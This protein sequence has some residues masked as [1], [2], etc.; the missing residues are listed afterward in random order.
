MIKPKDN[1]IFAVAKDTYDQIDK[2]GLC[3]ENEISIQRLK[4]SLRPF[5][6][7]ILDIDDKN[8]YSDF[9]KLK[10]IKNLR[11]DVAILKLGKEN[12]VVLINNVDYYQSLEH[13]FTG[14]T[15]FKQI[16]KD[17]TMTQLSTLQNYLKSLFKR[18]ELTEEQYKN[19]RPQNARAGRAHVLPKIH[20]PFT[21][22]PKFRLSVDTTSTCYYNVGSYLTELLNP[23][24]QNEFI[25]GDSFDATNKIKSVPPEFFDDG[26]IFAYFD[27]KSLFTNVPLQQTISIILDRVYDNKFVASTKRP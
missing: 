20:K 8:V 12:G 18:G 13:L 23:P 7:N 9:M 1:E 3:K 10:V 22:L 16:E 25:I 5:T 26:Y 21:V 27:V 24:T 15:K 6:F 4:N 19:L 11:K 17:T 14:Q 2:K